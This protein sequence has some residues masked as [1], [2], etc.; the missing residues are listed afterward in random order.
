MAERKSVQDDIRRGGGEKL[1]MVKTIAVC[2]LVIVGIILWLI[3]AMTSDEI[4]GHNWK[5]LEEMEADLARHKN[6]HR[7]A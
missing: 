3:N 5:S 2:F 7:K 1:S 6:K 4:N